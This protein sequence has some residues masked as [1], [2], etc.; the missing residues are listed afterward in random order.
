MVVCFI[1]CEAQTITQEFNTFDTRT[2][3]AV[4]HL[5]AESHMRSRTSAC[6]VL[7][8]AWHSSR[9][10]GSQPL[11]T[12]YAAS[13]NV[14][15]CPNPRR[16]YPSRT[17]SAPR[18]LL[19]SDFMGHHHAGL[20]TELPSTSN[21]DFSIA[22]R[23]K[24]V[25]KSTHGKT[26]PYVEKQIRRS[27]LAALEQLE[28]RQIRILGADGVAESSEFV[29]SWRT[30]SA[31]PALVLNADFRPLSYMPLSLWCWKDAVKAMFS[32][33]VSVVAH[34][35]RVIRSP[36]L[37][38][39]LPSVVALKDYIHVDQRPAFTRQNVFLRDRFTCQYCLQRFRPS[40]LS[41]DH[42]TPRCK[43]GGHSWENIVTAC[44][45]CNARKG[46]Q[47]PSEAGLK[48]HTK[49][50]LPSYHELQEKG[51]LFLPSKVHKDWVDYLS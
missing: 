27:E 22:C 3:D 18:R 9:R 19:R 4:L 11:H 48:L 8:S 49:P 38:M 10:L 12:T 14:S 16:K 35:D 6:W 37:E 42:V 5:K 44:L 32:D 29:S 15:S 43:G 31:H 13:A 17:A 51:R 47:F 25:G 2:A 23:L 40:E 41:F 45:A 39:R 21:R 33:K 36:S 34:Y 26:S 30:L 28:D 50:Y 1:F 24:S 20:Q 46:S 7:A